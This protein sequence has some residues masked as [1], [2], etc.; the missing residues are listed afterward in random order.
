[1]KCVTQHARTIRIKIF[2]EQRDSLGQENSP[3]SEKKQL[4]CQL[5][6]FWPNVK[7]DQRDSHKVAGVRKKYIHIFLISGHS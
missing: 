3:L 4:Q 6:G 5:T 1:M 2:I 7:W